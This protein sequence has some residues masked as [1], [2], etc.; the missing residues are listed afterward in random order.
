MTGTYI[1]W[2]M[3]K[4]PEP[5]LSQNK[6]PVAPGELPYERDGDV[7]RIAKEYK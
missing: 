1:N 4:V 2:Y 7:R 5:V 6:S 3:E